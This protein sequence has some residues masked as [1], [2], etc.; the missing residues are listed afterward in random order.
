MELE[1]NKILTSCQ[2]CKEISCCTFIVCVYW[3]NFSEDGNLYDEKRN[4]LLP[5]T[6]EKLYFS[7]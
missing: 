3:K 2:L 5:K 7:A 4:L 6:G 1:Q